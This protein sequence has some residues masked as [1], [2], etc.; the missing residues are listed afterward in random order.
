MMQYYSLYWSSDM[1]STVIN[2]SSQTALQC[3]LCWDCSA[4][5]TTK[6]F[7]CEIHFFGFFEAL[8]SRE[9][10]VHQNIITVTTGV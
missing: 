6:F 8:D 3:A 10:Y 5:K 2:E 1:V 9:N 4:E 7:V